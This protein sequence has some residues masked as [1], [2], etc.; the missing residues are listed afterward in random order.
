MAQESDKGFE[1]KKIL[2]IC[3]KWKNVNSEYKRCLKKFVK[4]GEKKT[5][6]FLSNAMR[7]MLNN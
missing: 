4:I 3:M 1:G 5:K 6:L 7:I 2:S